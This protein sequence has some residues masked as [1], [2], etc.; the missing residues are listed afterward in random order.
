MDTVDLGHGI[1]LPESELAFS[2]SRSSGPGGQ[3][4]NR[5]ETKVE[6]RWDVA[7]SPVLSD[8]QREAIMRELHSYLTQE[9]VLLLTSGETRSQ[10]HNRDLV[11]RR[12]QSL[13]RQALRPR[14]QRRPT[15]PT[16]TAR[17]TRL[18]RKK[19]HGQKKSL[20]GRVD[21]DSH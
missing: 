15:K 16:A 21:P 11:I 8:A 18:Q 3:H 17:A 1:S 10:R 4:V 2:F 6:L 19:A 14:R 5:S 20:R 12:L 13:V 7:Q 9:G